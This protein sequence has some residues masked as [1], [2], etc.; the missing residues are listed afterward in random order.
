[1]SATQKSKIQG[2]AIKRPVSHSTPLHLS[3]H[4]CPWW[5]VE[6]LK[7]NAVKRHHT[8][9]SPLCSCAT[10]QSIAHVLRFPMFDAR[11]PLP[12]P[13]VQKSHCFPRASIGPGNLKEY[14]FAITRNMSS[15]KFTRKSGM[16][17]PPPPKP[18]RAA[19]AQTFSTA[20]LPRTNHVGASST[21]STYRVR[22]LVLFYFFFISREGRSFSSS[23]SFSFQ[24]FPSL[25]R[26]RGLT[27]HTSSDH[28]CSSI[29][30]LTR[31][32]D[33]VPRIKAPT[34]NVI[35]RLLVGQHKCSLFIDVQLVSCRRVAKL[36]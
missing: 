21:T 5:Q 28:S 4:P 2:H 6:R 36:A 24:P 11:M 7:S 17:L 26:T 12:H 32:F 30:P 16:S 8:N 1:M 35:T 22:Q 27:L 3:H 9:A 31:Q 15:N 13:H 33:K 18:P 19:H 23:T 25:L 29:K 14:P 20:C 34:I 10:F